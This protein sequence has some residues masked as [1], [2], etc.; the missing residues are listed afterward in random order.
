MSIVKTCFIKAPK[1]CERSFT[2]ACLT[3]LN[4]PDGWSRMGVK[5]T[6]TDDE[7]TADYKISLA[8]DTYIKNKCG[9][10]GM[11]CTIMTTGICFIN[12]R[13]WEKGSDKSGLT[14]AGY[15]KYVVNHEVGHMLGLDDHFDKYKGK[16]P[17]RAP[18]MVQHT[19]GTNGYKANNVPL[20]SEIKRGADNIGIKTGPPKKGGEAFVTLNHMSHLFP[21]CDVDKLKRLK[22]HPTSIYMMTPHAYATKVFDI[23]E[24]NIGDLGQYSITDASSN[25]GGDLAGMIPRFNKINSVELNKVVFKF[26]KHNM[27]VLY[28]GNKNVKYA[29]ANY[30]DVYKKLKQD[31]VYMDPPWGE[32]YEDNKT[33]SLTY[34]DAK[35][36][37]R[38]IIATANELYEN[39]MFIIFKVPLNYKMLDLKKLKKW[40]SSIFPITSPFK[41]RVKKYTLIILNK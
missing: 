38:N 9:F 13:N 22:L 34:T 5:F 11:S 16:N 40:K 35:G 8:T 36:V 19:I 25:A 12:I 33:M 30:M 32:H 31:I 20:D 2:S 14:L 39:A 10:G 29:N 4:S 28:P 21:T 1:K 17:P 26:L 24:S 3:I 15:R 23:I 41:K 18:V 6:K 27:K 7:K 37:D